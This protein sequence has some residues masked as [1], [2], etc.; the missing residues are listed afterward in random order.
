MPRTSPSKGGCTLAK[1]IVTAERLR[2][3]LH[4]DPESGVFTWRVDRSTRIRAGSVAGSIQ[5]LGRTQ[6]LYIMIDFKQYR[7]HRLV[8]LYVYGKWPAEMLDHIN[9]DGA[10]NRLANLR[11]ATC[12]ENSQAANKRLMKNNTSGYRGV[13]FNTKRKRWMA[14]ISAFGKRKW[15]GSYETVEAAAAAYSEAKRK[16]HAFS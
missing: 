12:A 15:L 6:Y 4:Y 2:E 10:D 5:Y 1:S 14:S 16:V 9:G 7:A 11:E 13:S 3:L 8:W